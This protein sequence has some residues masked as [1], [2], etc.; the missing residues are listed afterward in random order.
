LE[1]A[2]EAMAAKQ[3]TNQTREE[4]KMQ[5]ECYTDNV[6]KAKV[7]DTV[8][9]VYSNL[10]ISEMKVINM[11]DGSQDPAGQLVAQMLTSYKTLS[12]AIKE[13]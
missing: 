8:K 4:L 11:G 6:M 3:I 7:L 13:K 10:K 5:A 1:L 9:T 2:T 12:A